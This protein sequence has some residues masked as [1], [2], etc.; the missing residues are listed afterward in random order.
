M[1][2]EQ[3]E[4]KSKD[5]VPL[6]AQSWLPDTNPIAI[7]CHIHG[8]SDHSSR[9]AHVASFF[10]KHNI[11]FFAIDL[12]GHGKSGGKRGHISKFNDYLENVELLKDEAVK[13]L[14]GVPIF[15]Y[16][17]SMG[18]NIVLNQAYNSRDKVAGYIVTSPWIK[19]AFD[20]PKMKIIFGSLVNSIYPS[21]SQPTGLDANLISHDKEVVKN[22]MNDELVHGKIT[23]AAYFEIRKYGKSILENVSK[24]HYPI[25]LMHGTADQLTSFEASKELATKKKKM[26]TF[27][28]YEGLFHELHNEPQKEIVF[29]D[30]LEWI[31][32][33][34]KINK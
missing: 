2:H 6:F 12:V 31:K 7:I 22:Y 18:G 34:L 24:L 30:M 15:I 11:A 19:L 26:I 16:G 29:N 1:K 8:Q 33:Q 21:L 32:E 13:K 20:P 28:E 17:H 5:D 10:V 25:L 4:W 23:T 27:I 3:Y 14:P 9:F